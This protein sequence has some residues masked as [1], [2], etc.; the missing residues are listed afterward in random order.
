[1]AWPPRATGVDVVEFQQRAG[2]ATP[3]GGAHKRALAP[4]SLPHRA[5]HLGGDVPVVRRR[6]PLAG[7]GLIGGGELAALELADGR[8]EGAVEHPRQIPRGDLVTEQGLQVLQLV[9]RGLFEGDLE[10]ESLG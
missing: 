7:A 3:P 2:R 6:A 9:V 4:V 1:M 10:R 8:V 5:P